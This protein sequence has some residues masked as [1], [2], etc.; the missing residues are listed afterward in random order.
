MNSSMDKKDEFPWFYNYKKLSRFIDI[1]ALILVIFWFITLNYIPPAISVY[2]GGNV[3]FLYLYQFIILGTIVLVCTVNVLAVVIFR[4]FFSK[5]PT[6]RKF[7]LIGFNL[8]LIACYQILLVSLFYIRSSIILQNINSS[9]EYNEFSS[10][11]EN[12][13]L[14]LSVVGFFFIVLK[15]LHFLLLRSKKR[16]IAIIKKNHQ[17]IIKNHESIISNLHSELE[18]L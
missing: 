13:A 9:L 18:D 8:A 3:Q 7:Q 2:S 10:M 12:V 1:L 4:K 16:R 14:I 17:D 6:L 5:T 11:V 15:L